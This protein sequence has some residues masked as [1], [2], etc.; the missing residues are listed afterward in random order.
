M[1]RLQKNSSQQISLVIRR[2]NHPPNPQIIKAV[3]IAFLIHFLF[4]VIFTI[5]PFH[6]SS[7][8]VFKPI[9]V[10]IEEQGIKADVQDKIAFQE[11]FNELIPE[12]LLLPKL[13]PI[14]FDDLPSPPDHSKIDLHFPILS[15]I[16]D[17][18]W[19]DW[20]PSL[21]FILER[22]AFQVLISGPLSAFAWNSTHS[23]LEKKISLNDLY[24]NYSQELIYEVLVDAETGKIFWYELIY[25]STDSN[26]NSAIED[27]LKSFIFDINNDNIIISG[28]VKITA[29]IMALM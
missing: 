23:V 6:I 26:A 13:Q 7:T 22:N 16:D 4:L 18:T 3:L 15:L 8:Y 19:L 29:P 10:E 14:V 25:N 21:P 24:S 17:E 5:S 11:F 1:F 20:K 28:K 2:K 9:Q 12:H 27:L